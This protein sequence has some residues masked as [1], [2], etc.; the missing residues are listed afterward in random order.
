MAAERE[1]PKERERPRERERE[2][3]QDRERGERGDVTGGRR[4]SPATAKSPAES[5]ERVRCWRRGEM[6]FF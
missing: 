2:R 1:R 3:D 5:G 4:R 6:F